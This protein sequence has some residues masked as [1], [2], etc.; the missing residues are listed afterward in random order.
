M[1]YIVFGYIFAKG[2]SGMK[3]TKI[4]LV[5][6]SI[7]LGCGFT[8]NLAK[9]QM[10]QQAASPN[11]QLGMIFYPV[12]RGADGQQYITTRAGYKVA[13]PGL[14]IDPNASQIA[15]YKDPQNN[16]WYVDKNNTP[17]PVSAQQMQSVMAQMQNQAMQRGQ[18]QYAQPM[19]TAP[20]QAAAPAATAAPATQQSNN[21]GNNSG[22]TAMMSGL[23]AAGGAALGAG[24]V[25]AYNNNNNQNYPY[26]NGAYA[27]HGVPYGQPIYKEPTG[28]YYYANQSGAHV[29]ITTTSSTEPY[30]NQYFLNLRPVHLF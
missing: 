20:A 17:T 28:Q 24:V 23:A 8:I 26:A 2:V 22:N 30:F 14:G 9:A 13:V 10:P 4:V 5:A 11:Q 12:E 25:N 3:T 6:I 15:V 21:N 7:T 19:Q 18:V 27:Y 16:F 1:I 29:P